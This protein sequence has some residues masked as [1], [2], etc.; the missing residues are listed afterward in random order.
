M[1][2]FVGFDMAVPAV[3]QDAGHVIGIGPGSQWWFVMRFQPSP[4]AAFHTAIAVPLENDL[5]GQRPAPPI[6]I[7][8]VLAHPAMPA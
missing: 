2:F 5:A 3:G 8:M 4:L 6:E 1:L 7:V